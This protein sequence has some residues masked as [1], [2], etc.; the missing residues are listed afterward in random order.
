M[1]GVSSC[2][3]TKD[4]DEKLLSS[5]YINLQGIKLES[6]SGLLIKSVNSQ[7]SETLH[8]LN[9]FWLFQKCIFYTIVN[10]LKENRIRFYF[11]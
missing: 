4:F 5:V 7:K 10:I 2:L 3:H 8:L 6:P 11:P 9:N 1:V